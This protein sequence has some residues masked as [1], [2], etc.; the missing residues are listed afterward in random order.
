MTLSHPYKYTFL[1]TESAWDR[2]LIAANEE[3]HPD[4][5]HNRIASRC[6]SAAA[7]FDLDILADGAVSFG[8]V[9]SWSEY[10]HK[11]DLAVTKALFGSLTERADRVVV[12]WGGL[13]VDQQ[14]LT[15]TAMEYGLVLPPQLREPVFGGRQRMHLDLSLAMRAG[16]KTWHHLSEV[17]YR[18]GVPLSLLRN[19]ARFFETR[20]PADWHLLLGHC[21]ADTLITAIVM[22]AW[23]IAQGSPGLRFEPAVIGMIGA[24]LRQRPA[25][26]MA[27]A[28]KA[29]SADLERWISASQEAA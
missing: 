7:L 13:P 20:T 17:A 5:Q 19:K 2:D 11:S 14:V 10:T 28:L 26:P 16:G 25:H 8:A 1:D 12:T 29:F 6:I 21:E 27:V 3:I 24:F 22:I 4:C 15:L 18:I 23:R 9:N